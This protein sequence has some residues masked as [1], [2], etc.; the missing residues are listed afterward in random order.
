MTIS[1]AKKVYIVGVCGVGMT[2]LACALSD[3]GKTV[4][5]SDVEASQNTPSDI[6]LK[7]AGI[8]VQY[9]FATDQ[10]NSE[11]DFVVTPTLHRGKDN[12]QVKKAKSLGIETLSYAEVLGQLVDMCPVSISVCGTHG[13]TTTTA[14]M[15]NI[16]VDLELPST[17]IVGAP[18]FNSG[19][20]S[21]ASTGFKYGVFEADEYITEVDHD[22]TPKILY[23]Q[24][25]YAICTNI[26]FDHPDVYK[27]IEDVESVFKSFF[28]TLSHNKGT[29]FYCR[30]NK[31]LTDLATDI[32]EL[33][34]VS[35][36]LT[37]ADY[38]A[39][40][41]VLTDG[42]YFFSVYFRDNKL[43]DCTMLIQGEHNI[44]N[45][46]SVIAMCHHLGLDLEDVIDS[47]THF[48]PARRRLEKVYD[49]G[50][51]LYDDYAHHPTEIVATTTTLRAVS[52][53]RRIVMIFQPHTYTRTESLKHE[54]VDAFS[55][56]DKVYLLPIYGSV[57]EKKLD[58]AISS[59]VLVTMGLKKGIDIVNIENVDGAEAIILKDLQKND[60]ILTAGAGDQVFFLRN[61]LLEALNSA[62]NRI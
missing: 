47:I 17:Y 59:Q 34:L 40:D 11:I 29:L 7:N 31:R 20:K 58:N 55:T 33:S 36:G 13:K 22:T 6:A 46:L 35:Y 12:P 62:E 60:V 26:D 24:P 56:V 38:T 21:G 45:A 53:S 51:T 30:D 16:F 15:A 9:N 49:K 43:T 44:L 41:V 61:Q 14:L 27:S 32:L 2:A 5:G 10:I 54:F 25:K 50:I 8:V 3:M 42:K 52:G 48:Y 1:E 37:D 18:D 57:R 19:R 4:L 39:R 28:Q 23:Q